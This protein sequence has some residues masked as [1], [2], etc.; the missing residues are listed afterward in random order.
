MIL[1]LFGLREAL[2][3]ASIVAIAFTGS[4]G[5]LVYLAAYLLFGAPHSE[6]QIYSG[7][8]R[9]AIDFARARLKGPLLR[10]K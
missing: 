6:R 10:M 3:P 8:A 9:Q 4:M 2:Q 7:Y 1:A 5:L